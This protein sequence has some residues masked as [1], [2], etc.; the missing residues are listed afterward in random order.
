M[1]DWPELTP[2]DA[3]ND[4]LTRNVCPEDWVN[5]TP[6]GRYNL[7]VIGAG[8]AGLITAAVAAGLAARQV[9][10]RRDPQRDPRVGLPRERGTRDR[11]LLPLGTGLRQ[12]HAVG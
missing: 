6:A 9:R 8:A 2:R 4:T 3:Y 5:P 10:H 12:R 1:T 11:L 7:V